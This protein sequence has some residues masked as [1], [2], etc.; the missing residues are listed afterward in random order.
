MYLCLFTLFI[1]DQDA[2]DK[3]TSQL[4]PVLKN[5]LVTTLRAL[6]KVKAKGSKEREDKQSSALTGK[7]ITSALR[8]LDDNTKLV[9]LRRACF[10]LMVCKNADDVFG[11]VAL[12]SR[13]ISDIKRAIDYQDQSE[14]EF[15]LKFIVREFVN[16]R[17]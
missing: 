17:V 1:V 4:L 8:S 12:S 6:S 7:Q 16:V 11:L 5:E 14:H 13:A 10:Q 3:M 2:V 9:A 15:A